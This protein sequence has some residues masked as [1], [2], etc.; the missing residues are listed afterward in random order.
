MGTTCVTLLIHGGRAYFVN[1]GDSRAYLARDGKLRQVTLDHSWVAEQVRAGVLTEE[2]ARVHA[3][4]N[5]ITRSLG[6][7]PNVNADLFIETLREG[8]RILLCSDG[9]HGYVEEDAIERAVLQGEQPDESVQALVDMANDERRARQ[10]HCCARRNCSKCP[11]SPTRFRCRPTPPLAPTAPSRSRCRSIPRR[12]CRRSSARP[13][14]WQPRRTTKPAVKAKAKAKR[15][16]GSR[17]ALNIVRLL[18]V[19]AVIALG[20][21]VWDFTNG[22][23]AVSRAAT[24]QAQDDISGARQT[25]ATAQSQDPGQA[26]VAL[27]QARQ[28]L[29]GDLHNAQARR[30]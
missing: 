29:D 23:I 24:T 8:D 13:A 12:A 25:I 26:L 14:R 7:Q 6:T 27:A 22:P 17:V 10:H 9:L 19:A 18:A 5:V 30:H 28:K 20:F 15:S 11:P 1:I 2:Q 21:G 3:H 4:R 16:S